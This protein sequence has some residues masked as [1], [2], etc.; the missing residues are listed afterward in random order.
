MILIYTRPATP[1]EPH[2]LHCVSAEQPCFPREQTTSLARSLSPQ[3][4]K[5][6]TADQQAYF[7]IRLI[8]DETPDAGHDPEPTLFIHR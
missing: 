6:A 8:R 2:H 4:Q 5:A 1:E 3:A 7:C